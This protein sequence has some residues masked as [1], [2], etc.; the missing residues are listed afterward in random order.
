[1]ARY[2]QL[3]H[4]STGWNGKDFSGPVTLIPD[5]GSDSVV[6]FDGRWSERRCIDHARAVCIARGRNGFTM[7]SGPMNRPYDRE[8]R[9]LEVVKPLPA[10]PVKGV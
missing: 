2:A 4:P 8:T 5:C 3:F 1:M 10:E 6:Y 7:Q 9:A